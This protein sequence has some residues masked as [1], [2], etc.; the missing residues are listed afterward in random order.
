MIVLANRH[1]ER[2]ELDATGAAITG[3]FVRDRLGR[4]ADVSVPEGGSAGKVVGRYANRIAG[5]RFSLD[6]RV[7]YLAKNEGQNTLHGGPEGFAKR[8]WSPGGLRTTG[9]G[10]AWSVEFT[11]N[12]PDGD[13]GFPGNL[14]CSA[15]YTFDDDGAL[16]IQYGA[17]VDAP[18]VINLTNHV[19]FNLSAVK[20]SPVAEQRLRIAAERYTPVDRAMI[21]T[22]D[23]APVE[24]TPY[25][26]R[27]MRAIGK[28][29]YDVNLVLDGAA[30]TLR[31]VAEAFDESTGR[32]LTVETTEPALQLYT[33]KPDAFALET[34]H[35]PDSPNHPAFP[36]TALRPGQAF[37]ST[38]IY[39]FTT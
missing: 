18:T 31:E 22:G 4:I 3:L 25:D 11:L 34:Q 15:V 23:V 32:R 14:H 33:G 37:R 36:S 19:Y 24:G 5:G 39:R 8:K 20:G 9:G 10:S 28:Q 35:F 26:F 1:H 6:G 12:S 7:Y 21:P 16:T 17:T 38:T 27:S 29:P 30:G 13:Q 2:V